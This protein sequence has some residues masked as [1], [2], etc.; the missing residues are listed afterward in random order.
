MSM[1]RQIINAHRASIRRANQHDQ[2]LR[3][4][5]G[6]GLMF[7]LAGGAWAVRELMMRV[8]VWQVTGG[9]VLVPNLWLICFGLWA[10]V[11]LL[12]LLALRQHGFA[13]DE[14]LLLMTLP[15]PPAS[16]FRGLFGLIMVEELATWLGFATLV[17][18]LALG[19][20]LG[21]AGIGWVVL[22]MSGA[23]ACAAG[24]MVT[25][26]VLLAHPRRSWL[27][28]VA[29]GC[30]LVTWLQATRP[31]IS[32][33]PVL[34]LLVAG[35]CLVAFGL[36]L[37]PRAAWAG[38]HYEAVFVAFQGHSHARPAAMLP[39][40]RALVMWLAQWRT[41]T[42]ALLTRMLL[43]QSR[44]LFTWVRFAAISL[45]L[46]PFPWIRAALEP[47]GLAPAQI[48]AGYV[49]VLVVLVL[50][51]SAASPVGGEANRL[52][53]LLTAP[54]PPT[55]WL[56]AK[57]LVQ[58]IPSLLVA[59]LASCALGAWSGLHLAA[60]AFVLA[61]VG[62]VVSGACA[63][64]VYGSTWDADLTTEVEG[65]I[66]SLVLEE[67]PITPRRIALAMLALMAVAL[68][69]L[70]LWLLP[71]LGSLLL[72]ALCNGLLLVLLPYFGEA[73]VQRLLQQA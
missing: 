51:D 16:R 4:A 17:L 70:V 11:A 7:G 5:R 43:R 6:F 9:M 41:P 63:L 71:P 46:L 48:I 23:L 67:A 56:H 33:L 40:V 24:A 34:P 65:A 57:L 66:Q 52:T 39:G 55:Q 62:C 15:V 47:R 54:L 19:W 49:V 3:I 60:W 50:V 35:G 72:L 26:F 42:G 44:S 18:A 1:A 20:S 28:I 12:A 14:S 68:Q 2:R 38:K 8:Q 22:A 58:L 27:G 21:V 64:F 53:L 45:Y 37:G 36:L 25:T 29:L 32:A 10:G 59:A 13:S 30:I 61:V 73:Q 69:L 31:G